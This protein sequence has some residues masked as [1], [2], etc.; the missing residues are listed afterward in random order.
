MYDMTRMCELVESEIAKIVEKGLTGANIELAYK[1]VDM[2][3]DL[4]EAD[5][6]EDGEYSGRGRHYVRGHYSMNDGRY[7]MNDGRMMDRYGDDYSGAGRYGSKYSGA[8]RNLDEYL[9]DYVG[10]LEGMMRDAN[11]DERETI[12][13]Y[14]GKIKS[15]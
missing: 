4:K 3:K 6:M 14:I 13:R 10:Q 8:E 12:K 1:L 7:S 5:C 2:Y 11:P 9:T 15:M